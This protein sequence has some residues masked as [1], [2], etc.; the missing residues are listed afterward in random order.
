M[1]DQTTTAKSAPGPCVVDSD[2][3]YDDDYGDDMLDC[4]CCA[5]CGC[6]CYDMEDD[7]EDIP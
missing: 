4:G 7:D 3:R 5:C 1:A 2:P 6:S